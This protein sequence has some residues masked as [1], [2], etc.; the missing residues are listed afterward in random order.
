MRK[1]LATIMMCL[2]LIQPT[3]AK[4][5]K[6]GDMAADDV[7]ALGA[8]LMD[9]KTGRVLWG[10]N[11][12][13]PLPMA[14]TTKIMTAIITL[15]NGRLDDIVKVSK[16][17][18][19]APEVKMFLHAGEEIKLE[20]LLYALMLQSSNDA[21]VAIA[22]HIGGSVE[23]FCKQMTEKAAAL[24]AKDTLFETPSGLDTANH[25]STA[26]DMA[27]IARYAMENEKFVE[28]INTQNISATSSRRTYSI[29]N[30]NRLLHEFP[31]ANGIKTGFTGKAGQ[32]FVGA[33]KR[34]D[35]QLIS[36]V[37]ASG[38]GSA[39]KEQKWKDTK[40]LLNHGFNHYGYEHIVIKD[41]KAGEFMVDRS[42]TTRMGVHFGDSYMVPLN[43]AER[44]SIYIEI[45][46]P[47]MIRAPITKGQ[48]IGMAKVFISG[49]LFEEVAILADADAPRHDLK[50][51]LEKIANQWLQLG[52]NE[53]VDLVLPEF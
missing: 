46:M 31:G 39:G 15:E 28:I 3:F 17:A 1:T 10:K 2:F 27:L 40:A 12:Y 49:K 7:A 18:A 11:A 38:W 29:I 33:A 14:S 50:T 23:A 25:H 22:E 6:A 5:E 47:K 30:K 45:D 42:K 8:I 32:C 21:A 51:S 34:G 44:E 16:R 20:Y 35:M 43:K 48:T 53:Q 41:V 52:T 24:G 13:T 4:D 26:Y 37:L 36:V 19:A 9:G